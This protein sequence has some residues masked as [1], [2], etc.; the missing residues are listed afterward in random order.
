MKKNM[1]QNVIIV[2]DDPKKRR[3]LRRI[4]EKVGLNVSCFDRTSDC[5]EQLRSK[6]P[7]DLLIVDMKMPRMNGTGLLTPIKYI[8][9]SLPVLVIVDN[10]D[11]T[12][13]VTAIRTGASDV[14]EKPLNRE[15]LLSAIELTLNGNTRPHP[16]VN[17]VL[18]ETEM[19]ILHLI[20]DSKSNKEISYLLHR[21]LRTIEGHRSRIMRKLGVDNVVHLVEKSI[22]MGLIELPIGRF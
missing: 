18:T 3:V 14:I 7:C 10:G 21:S 20:L 22:E 11:V 6:R 1:K 8:L 5:L 12:T 9:P 15:S 2:V 16:L 13:A 4:L 19:R 17:S